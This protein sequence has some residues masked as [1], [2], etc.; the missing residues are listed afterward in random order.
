[1]M[2]PVMPRA[3]G[4]DQNLPGAR[5]PPGA[6]SLSA[7]P[8]SCCQKSLM[9]T[10]RAL[11]VVL[12]G[13]AC[14]AWLGCNEGTRS[15]APSPNASPPRAADEPS[16]GAADEQSPGGGGWGPHGGYGRLYDPATEE[17]IRGEVVR[18]ERVTP[19][20]GMSGGVHLLVRTGDGAT[21]SAHLG[22]SWYIDNQDFAIRPGD[23]VEVTGSRVTIDGAPA[24][25]AR[26]V[27]RGDDELVLRD[28]AGIPMWSASRRR[29]GP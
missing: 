7:G 19:M 23:T 21:I 18:V 17:T 15:A 9:T 29:G 11:M 10:M 1:M 13:T 26:L 8:A 25:I 3:R 5:V 4:P 2:I 20:H 14:F 22:P 28:Q 6:P 12:V 16:P 27:A 24:V